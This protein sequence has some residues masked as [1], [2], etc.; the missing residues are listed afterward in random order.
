MLSVAPLA[1]G[2]GYYLEL[3]NINYY[4]LGGEPLP[5]WHGTAAKEFGLSGVAQ[6]EHVERLCAGYHHE[7]EEALVQN[8]GTAKRNPGQDLT[9][10]APK[11]VSIAW[12]VADPAL[13]KA[14]EI[15]QMDA[16]KEALDFIEDKAGRA[17]IGKDGQTVVKSPLLFALFEHGT[18][19]ALDPQLHTHALCINLTM[20]ADGHV[21]AADTTQLYMWKMAAGAMYRAALAR[22]MQELGF[23]VEQRRVGA[24][25]GFELKHI[26][27]DLIEEFSKR[28]AE[29]EALLKLRAGGLDTASPKYAE[30][31]TKETRRTKDTER[32]RQ[33]L[34][35]EWQIIAA[36]FGIRG[37]YLEA[38]REPIGVITAKERAERKEAIYREAIEAL[39]ENHSH[40]NEATLTKAVA[41][42]AAG[43]ISAREA[44]DLVDSKMRGEELICLGTL[45]TAKKNEQHRRYIDQNEERYTTPE[46]IRLEREMLQNAERIVR[47]PDTGSHTKRI[48]AAISQRTTIDPEQAEAVRWLCSGPGVRLMTG[49]AGAGKT[50][51]LQT[52]NEV[53]KSEGRD[54]IGCS[55]AGAAAKRLE[56]GTGIESRTLDSLLWN[57]DKGKISLDSRSVVVVDEAG[58]VGTKHMARLLEHVANAPGSRL[59][60]VG[61]AK[62]L[63]PITAG[64]PFKH[65]AE[66]YGETKLENIRRQEAVWAREAVRNFERG[67]VQLAIESYVEQGH[68]HLT[69]NRPEAMAQLVDRW[70]KDGGVTEPGKVLM[71]ASLNSEVKDLNLRAQA[72][73]I[74]A[75][76]VDPDKKLF[77]NGVFFHQGDRLQ[78]QKNSKELG[79]TNSDTGTVLK[80]NPLLQRLTVQLDDSDRAVTV[81]L[82][83]YAPAN[84]KLGYASTTHKAQGASIPHVHVLMGG[85]LTDFHMGYVQASRSQISTHIFC[86]Q[87][88]AGEELR[89]LVNA[90]RVERPKTLAQ[91]VINENQQRAAEKAPD[92][93]QRPEPDRGPSLGF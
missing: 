89:T 91:D 9:F 40:W 59:V 22:G 75:G 67:F 25:V 41:E 56:A 19:R 11:S 65:L 29:I 42:R 6:R 83:R 44:R 87:Q 31:V 5:V 66:V 51:T 2:P 49:I 63:Q 90:L 10:S 80:V 39:S 64:G 12:A 27:K 8:A 36:E 58:M 26:P 76:E 47:G 14:I 78:F 4:V 33:Q 16:V 82:K 34:L 52:C 45:T 68:F 55:I 88:E 35:H 32:P 24:S 85:P 69:K 74:K 20:H 43:R 77:A 71:L 60:L 61:D 21:T 50:F 93:A 57:L 23:A 13:R 46:I 3:A 72:E 28:R 92:R 38:I 17:R 86:D 15:K 79:V 54:V 30:M 18:S 7:T 37:S 48:E 81:S 62:Q 73:R 1:Q 84:I 70:K 53:W